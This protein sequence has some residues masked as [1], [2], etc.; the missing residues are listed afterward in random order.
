MGTGGDDYAMMREVMDRRFAHI[1]D[2]GWERPDLLLIDGGI[3][4]VNAV[5]GVLED[6]GLSDI[7]VVGI[8]K[9]LQRNA[10]RE[11]FIVPEGILQGRDPFQLPENSPTLHLLQRLRDEAHRYGIS[12][13]RAKREK[14]L[15]RSLLDAIPGI[16]P[17]RKKALLLHFGSAKHVAG[18]ALEDL[19]NV[20]GIDKSVAKKIYQYF[21]ET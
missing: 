7:P 19:L 13:H 4:Q 3:G 6:K 14:T 12:A 20:T 17:S 15:R 10:G 8:A 5:L 2:E 16:G 1:D 9:G 21:H 11:T 18:A